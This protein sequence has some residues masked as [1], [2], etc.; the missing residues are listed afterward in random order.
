LPNWPRREIGECEQPES[1]RPL[2]SQ[3]WGSGAFACQGPYAPSRSAAR[4]PALRRRLDVDAPAR[5]I[6][7]HG[8]TRAIDRTQKPVF[9]EVSMHTRRRR[10]DVHQH[11][12]PPAY[13]AWLHAKGIAEAGGRGI[14]AW[15]AEEALGVMDDHDIATGMLSVSTPGVSL[16][17]G[18]SATAEA[19]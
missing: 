3:L 2:A 1:G 17:V 10:I 19:R 15:S 8:L 14:P 4:P 18:S 13:A 7:R 16:G 12:V 6:R 5:R 11:I 9:V